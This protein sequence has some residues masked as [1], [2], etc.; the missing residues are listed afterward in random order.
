MGTS[1]PL[2]LEVKKKDVTY[3]KPLRR[4]PSSR[5]KRKSSGDSTAAI[6]RNSHL[7]LGETG[8]TGFFTLSFFRVWAGETDFFRGFRM[9]YGAEFKGTACWQARKKKESIPATVRE[10]P[11]RG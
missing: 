8:G 10:S 7:R 9:D 11:Y 2:I 3:P 6:N 4:R 1:R 5:N